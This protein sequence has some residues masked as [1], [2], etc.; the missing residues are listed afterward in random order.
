MTW[1]RSALWL[2]PCP[3]AQPR[4]LPPPW[5]ILCRDLEPHTE[6]PSPVS[7]QRNFLDQDLIMTLL[8]PCY[9]WGPPVVSLAPGCE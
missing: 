2:F 3:P 1:R 7:A 5:S 4:D 9:S 8:I 6:R